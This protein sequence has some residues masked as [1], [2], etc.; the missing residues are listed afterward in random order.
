[1]DN[2]KEELIL[3]GVN[4]ARKATG[5]CAVKSILDNI[6]G[7][8]ERCRFETKVYFVS[9]HS[10]EVMDLFIRLRELGYDV[11]ECVSKEESYNSYTIISWY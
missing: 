8:I 10:E 9:Q 11:Q 5:E 7:A 4:W 2:D 1:M 3:R 6:D